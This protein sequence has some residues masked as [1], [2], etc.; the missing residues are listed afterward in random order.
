[1]NTN[2]MLDQ[3]KTRINAKVQ[4]LKLESA[5][6]T[7]ANQVAVCEMRL[8]A[9]L[10]ES[11]NDTAREIARAKFLLSLESLEKMVT[12]FEKKTLKHNE[13]RTN[14]IT[15]DDEVL[16]KRALRQAQ[17]TQQAAGYREDYL[18]RMAEIESALNS[19]V[20]SIP[21]LQQ[22]DFKALVTTI[23]RRGLIVENQE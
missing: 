5:P 23:S 14:G 19:N 17:L 13:T 3:I 4:S 6:R 9:S 16:L 11:L 21:A 10:I 7:I 2:E 12:E 22:E 20:K 18:R 8:T 1:M 15:L